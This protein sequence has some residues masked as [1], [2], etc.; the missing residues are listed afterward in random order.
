MMQPDARA[1]TLSE[2]CERQAENCKYTSASLYIWQKRAQFWR[3]VFLVIPVILSGFATSEILGK[4]LGATGQFVAAGTGLLAGLFPAI[5]VA[6]NMDMKVMEIGRAATE[7]TNLRDRFRQLATIKSLGDYNEFET[8]FETIMDRM[9]AARTS[10]PPVPEWCFKKAQS[11]IKKGD[12]EYDADF[13]RQAA[14][15]SRKLHEK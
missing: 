6:L 13:H 14:P 10:S 7:F 12:Y 2:E 11:K 1:K 9:D 15:H 4:Y 8:G 5:F 3:A